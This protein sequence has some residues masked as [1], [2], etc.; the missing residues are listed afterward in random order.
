MPSQDIEMTSSSSP[1]MKD[2]DM[3]DAGSESSAPVEAEKL[4]ENHVTSNGHLTQEQHEESSGKGDEEVAVESENKVDVDAIKIAE[5]HVPPSS[6]SPI[7]TS[8]SHLLPSVEKDGTG[9]PSTTDDQ[10]TNSP[11]IQTKVDRAVLPPS[12]KPL[13]VSEPDPGASETIKID[14]E[15]ARL[16]EFLAEVSSAAAQR[17]LKESWRMFLFDNY[18]EDHIAFIL[19]AGLRNAN[20]TIIE[21]VLRDEGLF[22]TQ[23]MDLIIKRPEFLE[24]ALQSAS[25]ALITTQV[26]ETVI[27]QVIVERL[28]TVPA[29]KLVQWLAQA[30]R[31]GYKADDILNED[32]ESVTPN[33]PLPPIR[34]RPLDEPPMANGS[35]YM[36]RPPPENVNPYKD[37]LLLEQERNAS[38]NKFQ[39]QHVQ[40]AIARNAAS[41]N[42]HRPGTVARDADVVRNPTSAGE[43][44]RAPVVLSGQMICRAC[45]RTFVTHSGFAYHV[46]KKVCD[47]KSPPGGF[48]WN[49]ANC[50]SGFTTKQGMDYHALRYVCY[51]VEE[52]A[53]AKTSLKLTNGSSISTTSLPP[54]MPLQNA[55]TFP[56]P[57]P[58]IYT[59][60][61]PPTSAPRSVPPNS[62]PIPQ[63]FIGSQNPPGTQPRPPVAIPR[64]PP[65]PAPSTPQKLKAEDEIRMS[66][67][68]LS[69]QK[70]AE[71]EKALQETQDRT[72]AAI[73]SL[74]ASYTEAERASRT[75]SMLNANAS[76]RSQIR[77]SF[78]VSL[79]LRKGQQAARVAAGLPAAAGTKMPGTKLRE[80]FGAASTHG[81]LAGAPSGASFS[82]INKPSSNA[83]PPNNG[84][85]PALLAPPQSYNA[86]PNHAPYGPRNLHQ[87]DGLLTH[88][89]NNSVPPPDSGIHRS[90]VPIPATS[91]HYHPQSSS[92]NSNK[93]KRDSVSTSASGTPAPGLSMVE[94]S[95]EDAAAKFANNKKSRTA[96]PMADALSVPPGSGAKSSVIEILSDSSDSEDI[97]LPIK[98]VEADEDEEGDGDDAPS[99][100]KLAGRPSGFMARRGGKH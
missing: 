89:N 6:V 36:S 50:L 47:K 13:K 33:V 31:L 82:P 14:K 85:S 22:K 78:G 28:E 92:N 87:E 69:P 12:K 74:P 75:S 4:D 70:R 2:V 100:S 93:R 24:K 9:P 63:G 84:Y 32:G 54:S 15:V 19:R 99:S 41:A 65:P 30:Q 42:S 86:L 48:K 26:P 59:T 21:R 58:Q 1:E 46:T 95:S 18:N 7:V 71:M 57:R 8:S 37:P 39:S 97:E 66:P 79:R 56:P 67:D 11:P 90:N 83:S 68:E 29:K 73:A 23:M 88:I 61:A 17:V 51:A 25:A 5:T 34:E 76:K 91:T 80:S 72:D 3:E 43:H 49:C 16:K 38:M 94:V 55:P 10:K 44:A 81:P 45:N 27:D 96:T 77:K 62:Q 20:A 98:S 64:P 60:Q 35:H 53:P 40:A 52:I